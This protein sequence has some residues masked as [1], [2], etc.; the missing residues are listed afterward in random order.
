[1]RR[2]LAALLL[3]A[4]LLPPAALAAGEEEG[5]VCRTLTQEEMAERFLEL[6][7]RFPD[8]SYWNREL[9][10]TYWDSDGQVIPEVF[11]AVTDHP[12]DQKSY[13]CKGRC[14]GFA[15]MMADLLYM[16]QATGKSYTTPGYTRIT[17]RDQMDHVEPGDIISGRCGD[18]NHEA[19]VW[20][21]ENG[22]VYVA[23]CWG[24]SKWGCRVNWFYFDGKNKYATWEAIKAATKEGNLVLYRHPPYAET[25]AEELPE[26]N[27]APAREPESGGLAYPS[28]Q[29]VLLDG[30]AVALQMCALVDEGGGLTNYVSLR[31]LASVLSNSAAQF[32]VGWSGAVYMVKGVPYTPNGTEGEAPFE[33]PQPYTANLASLKLDGRTVTADTILLTDAAG[34]GYTYFKFRDLGELLGFDL[35][36]SAETGISVTTG[37]A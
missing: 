1:M 5:P 19:I 31:Q 25:A 27:A 26:G 23:E 12:C 14:V 34:G 7:E 22:K 13:V 33:G 20:K 32:D 37:G 18:F 35:D 8:G 6:K 21:V 17:D 2:I 11:E 3:T 15:W 9:H 30:E 10:Q 24:G 4:L 36:W 29:T 16:D 28:T